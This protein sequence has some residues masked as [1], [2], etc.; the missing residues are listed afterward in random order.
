MN[1]IIQSPRDATRPQQSNK[2]QQQS[3]TA[4]ASREKSRSKP[5]GNKTNRIG[6]YAVDDVTVQINLSRPD[7]NHA[8]R[9]Y[10]GVWKPDAST[11]H[12]L[13]GN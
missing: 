7:N 11:L 2:Q 6:D 1:V 13:Q 4:N 12:R 3:K 10:S 9:T 8:T 5:N